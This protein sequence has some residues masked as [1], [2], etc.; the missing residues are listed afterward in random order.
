ML[1]GFLNTIPFIASRYL[2]RTFDNYK[3]QSSARWATHEIIG[4][5]PVR[6]F[7]GQDIDEITFDMLLRSDLGI[8]PQ[9]EVEKLT[10]LRDKGT[11]VPLVIG[12]KVIGST[13]WTVESVSEQVQ[14][15][16]KLGN[17]LSISV[18]V[19]LKEYPD[20]TKVSLGK[21]YKGSFS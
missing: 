13:L 17:P 20:N 2:V 19:T 21:A 8:S 12:N 15:W 14:R 10:K 7:L 11:P 6:E 4:K 16:S 3:K 1:V 5:K 18:S 9:K